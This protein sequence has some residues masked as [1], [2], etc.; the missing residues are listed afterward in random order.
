MPDRKP[1]SSARVLTGVCVVVVLAALASLN[2]YQVSAQAARAYPDPY[3]VSSAERRFAAAIELLP[4]TD[5][6]GYISDLP[7]TETAGSTAFVAAQYVLA[8]RA[9]V[10]ADRQTTEWAVGN[11]GRPGDFAA[12]GKEAGFTMVRDFGSGVVVYRRIKP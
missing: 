8:P 5:V 9:L 12:R 6:I 4:A 2:S 11:F 7:L 10:L 1:A 3:G